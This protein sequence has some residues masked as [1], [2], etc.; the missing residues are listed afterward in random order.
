MPIIDAHIHY[1]DDAPELL[2]LLA[3]FDIRLLNISFA[4][5]SGKGWRTTAERYRS[6]AAQRPERFAWC[7]SFDLPRLDDPGYVGETIAQLAQDFAAGAVACK[8]WKNVGMELRYPDGRF[9]Q[10]DDPLLAPVF[11][12]LAEQ[13]HPLLAH[14]AEPLD[15]WLPL[16][17]GSPHY[18]YYSRN[19][20][21]HMYTRPD[22]PSHGE[23][24]AARNRVLAQHPSLRFVGAHL[25]SL[26]YDV[27]VLAE[28]FDCYPNLAV[29]ISAR[30][31]DLA[32][33]DSA[34]VRA[35]LTKYQDRVLFGTDV[36][37]RTPL[38]SLPPAERAQA[39]DA[40]R[41]VYTTHFAYFESK[42]PVTVRDHQTVGLGLSQNVLEKL[43]FKN[44]LNW[45]PGLQ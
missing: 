3:E 19:P 27:D 32:V 34:K 44:A 21:W 5:E 6:L 17:E 8:V 42:G 9:F 28:T 13:G 38:S 26:E 10:V 29:D 45:Y 43:Y 31:F 36:V 2:A 30:L 23:L 11:A 14:I 7:T 41:T 39:V 16:R 4:L 12:W 20:Q 40:L 1:G 33:Q 22:Y 15:C 37:M 24:M 18:G 35:F 25:A